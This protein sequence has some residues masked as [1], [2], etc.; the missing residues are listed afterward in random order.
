MPALELAAPVGEVMPPVGYSPAWFLLGLGLLI[1]VLAWYLLV[2]AAT[3]PRRA[4]APVVTAAP[5][6]DLAALQQRARNRVD[7]VEQE[8][9]GGAL[10]PREAHERLS[11]AVREYV[12]AATGIPADR[13]T[14]ADLERSP[15]RGTARAVA[16]FYPAM[17][18][19]EPPAELE[20]SLRAAREVLAGWR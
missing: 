9:R 2:A 7:E 12:A 1:A 15:L 20:G 16:R 8:A 3:R 10:D 19:A 6:V 18:A 14:L 11:G 4:A 17:F 5:E 13:M